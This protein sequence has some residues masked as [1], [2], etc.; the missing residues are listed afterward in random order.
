[1]D[2]CR[3]CKTPNP[4]TNQYCRVCGAVLAVPTSMVKAQR[5][6]IVPAA[7]TIRWKWIILGAWAT[8][9][10]SAILLGFLYVVA[11]FL[12]EQA[13]GEPAPDLAALADDVLALIVIGAFL[14][15]IAFGLGGLALGL[16]AKKSTVRESVIAA[17]LV[18]VLFGAAGS[19]LTADLPIIIGVLA[20]PS[21]ALAGLGGWLSQSFRQ[22][23][24]K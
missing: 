4:P 14:F 1:M 21:I 18:V 19:L 17:L 7:K 16:I 9:G 22:G 15:L 5:S 2:P 24:T 23:R 11:S 20:V 3:K 12:F 13:D 10:L 8:I 6:W